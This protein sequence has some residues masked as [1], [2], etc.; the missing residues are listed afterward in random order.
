MKGQQVAT[1]LPTP[2]SQIPC[3]PAI[4]SS[5][6]PVFGF[7]TMT[8]ATGFHTQFC[9]TRCPSIKL[10][11]IDKLHKKIRAGCE[12][13]AGPVILTGPNSPFHNGRHS[14][15]PAHPSGHNP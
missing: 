3:G 1:T 11:N 4:I 8:C 9:L 10:Y 7:C 12:N 5:G 13:K 15:F 6:Y 14:S 2:A